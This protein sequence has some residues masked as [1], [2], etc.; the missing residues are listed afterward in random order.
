MYTSTCRRPGASEIANSRISWKRLCL[1]SPALSNGAVRSIDSHAA[2]PEVTRSKYRSF[3]RLLHWDNWSVERND[4]FICATLQ[5]LGKVPTIS[6]L[7]LYFSKF[8]RISMDLFVVSF[9]FFFFFFYETVTVFC[10]FVCLFF[11][12]RVT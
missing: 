1:S 6:A 2:S 8:Q 10:L 11:D 3:D 12:L 7:C 4:A 9:S 5:R